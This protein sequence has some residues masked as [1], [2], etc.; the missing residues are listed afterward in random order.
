VYR[1]R[2][3]GVILPRSADWLEATK[4]LQKAFV[5]HKPEATIAPAI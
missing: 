1:Y 2:S 5:E 3:G 4:E